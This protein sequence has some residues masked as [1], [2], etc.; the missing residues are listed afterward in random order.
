MIL[1]VFLQFYVSL[2]LNVG[3]IHEFDNNV[4]NKPWK[5]NSPKAALK[6][7]EA[8]NQWYP[9]WRGDQSALQVDSVKVYAL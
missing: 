4:R 3:G 5:N 6:F 7:W 1:V 2:G 8:K 9:T